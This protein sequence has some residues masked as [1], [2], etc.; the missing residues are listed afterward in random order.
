MATRITNQKLSKSSRDWMREH[1]D[2]PFV[3]RAQ[4]EGY[5][6][7]AAYKLLEMQEKYKLIKPGMV[8]VDLGAAYTL[9]AFEISLFANNI[10]NAEYTET[11]F[12]P[13]PKGNLLFGIRYNFR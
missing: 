8:V 10:F 2:D 11:N 4:K 13:M 6:A 5:R 9:K 3:K 7:R 12:V 1:L